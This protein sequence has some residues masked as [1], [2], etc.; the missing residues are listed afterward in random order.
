MEENVKRN[1]ARKVFSDV[2]FL[3]LSICGGI[4]AGLTFGII[5]SFVYLIFIF[6]VIMGVVG[7]R[8]I[9]ENVKY[10]KTRNVSVV[11]FSSILTA[12][13]LYVAFH[14]MR[15]MGLWVATA[16]Q[17]FGDFSDK[18]LKAGRV[19]VEYALKKETGRSGFIGYMFYKAQ[20]GVSIGRI[21]SSSKLN[22]GPIFT[23][24]YWLIEVGVIGFI[25]FNTSKQIL[26]KP[27]CE[28]CNS[29][30]TEKKHIGGI[31]VTKEAE[32]LNSI[33]LKDFGGVGTILEENS[34]SPSLEF[35]IQSCKS[36]D[37][38]KS[39]LSMTQTRFLNGK[40]VFKEVSETTLKPSEKKLLVEGIKYLKN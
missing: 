18:S 17:A 26:K 16:L 36:C 3:F 7:G 33:R 6:P 29:W 20:Q 12:I 1:N 31:P 25:T 4:I 27:F 24:V 37:K 30:Y 11:M 28:N 19:V 5:G 10:T 38:S 34:E 21:F 40:L 15:Y 13:V 14:Y 23:W 8:I 9:T 35:Y 32:I 22:L 2:G 39:F